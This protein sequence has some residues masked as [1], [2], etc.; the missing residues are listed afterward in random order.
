MIKAKDD[1]GELKLQYKLAQKGFFSQIRGGCYEV[2]TFETGAE[3]CLV[4]S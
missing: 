3:D 1:R 2:E 4:E